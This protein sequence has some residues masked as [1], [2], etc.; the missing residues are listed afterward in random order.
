MPLNQKKYDLE[1]DLIAHWYNEHRPHE[2]LSGAAPNETYRREF[3]NNRKPRYEPR[4]HWPRGSP[5]AKPW[6]LVRGK[7]GAKLEL[8]VELH[9]GRR[10]LPIILLRRAS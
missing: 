9:G 1:L 8:S 7:P 2:F 10:H 5:C 3:A 4:S 6:A